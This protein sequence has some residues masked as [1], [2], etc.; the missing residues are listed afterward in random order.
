MASVKS[1]LR[2]YYR[3]FNA[4]SVVDAA[5]DWQAILDQ[6]FKMFLTMGGAMS[7]AELGLSIA[8]LIRQDKVHA[9][10]IAIRSSDA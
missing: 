4:P 3:H 10:C 9:L 5:D 1:F 7:T 6:N 8:Q 2:H